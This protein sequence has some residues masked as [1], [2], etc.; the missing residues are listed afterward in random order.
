MDKIMRGAHPSYG[1]SPVVLTSTTTTTSKA[2]PNK[3]EDLYQQAWTLYNEPVVELKEPVELFKEAAEA[4]HAVAMTQL[5]LIYTDEGNSE[6]AIRYKDMALASLTTSDDWAQRILDQLADYP[7][8]DDDAQLAECVNELEMMCEAHVHNQNEMIGKLPSDIWRPLIEQ[9]LS[10][11]DRRNL[12][13]TCTTFAVL[14]SGAYSPNVAFDLSTLTD[15]DEAEFR[16]YLKN[17]SSPHLEMRVKG[18]IN[19][20]TKE[21]WL[22]ILC[23]ELGKNTKI[24]AITLDLSSTEVTDAEM[25]YLYVY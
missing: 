9:N 14:E 13:K 11:V 10:G 2:V 8:K 16:Q 3:G 24:R 18:I 21:K 15:K 20:E 5:V 23:E 22:P 17:L 6:E 1:Y 25:P 4:G 7:P 12:A 19:K